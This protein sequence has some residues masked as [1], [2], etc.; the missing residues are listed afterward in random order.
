MPRQE[1]G[2]HNALADARH[3]KVMGEFLKAKEAG[4]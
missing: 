1:K 3:N 4:L 2:V